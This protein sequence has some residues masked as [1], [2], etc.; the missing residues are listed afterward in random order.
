M[1]T[2]DTGYLNSLSISY[3]GQTGENLNTRQ[4]YTQCVKPL[5]SLDDCEK[6]VLKIDL[7]QLG[8]LR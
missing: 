5:Q 4:I 1:G 2:G 6:S 8:Y 3:L 7:R